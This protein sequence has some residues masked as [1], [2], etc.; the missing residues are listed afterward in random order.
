MAKFNETID[1]EILNTAAALKVLG[2][3]FRLEI[4]RSLQEGPKSAGELEQIV[5]STQS[6]V[7][8]HLA[9]LRKSGI[10]AASREKN[11]IYYTAVN[12]RIF[13]LL[14]LARNLFG[15]E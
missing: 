5:G 1:K 6:N 11:H 8:Q 13:K 7:S 12:W 9:V 10:V 14:A 15:G 3:P 4:V 2:H